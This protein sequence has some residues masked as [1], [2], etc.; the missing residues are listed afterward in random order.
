MWRTEWTLTNMAAVFMTRSSK[1]W[2]RAGTRVR[3]VIKFADMALATP[4]GR[5]ISMRNSRVGTMVGL[6]P[7]DG[8]VA[9]VLIDLDGHGHLCRATDTQ[10]RGRDPACAGVGV[11]ALIRTATL[12]VPAA[13][14]A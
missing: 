12:D 13:A 1:S 8:P 6:G 9:G 3:L 2:R 7:H 11:F 14:R 5:V 4:P 10:R